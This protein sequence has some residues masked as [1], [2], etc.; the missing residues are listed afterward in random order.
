MSGVGVCIQIRKKRRRRERIKLKPVLY[1]IADGLERN[2]ALLE[3]R[4][5]PKMYRYF[6]LIHTHIPLQRSTAWRSVF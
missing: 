5:G 4:S 2:A 6:L 1:V 3:S